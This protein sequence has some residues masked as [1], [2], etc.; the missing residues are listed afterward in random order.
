MNHYIQ[1]NQHRLCEGSGTTIKNKHIV[2]PTC[3]LICLSGR[4]NIIQ[5]GLVSCGD[6]VCVSS[7]K[8]V[9]KLVA[10]LN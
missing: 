6:R 8:T 10:K 1:D 2:A 4:W 7:S 5:R 9:N 3:S